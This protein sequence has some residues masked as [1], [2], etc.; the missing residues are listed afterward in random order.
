MISRKQKALFRKGLNII[1]PSTIL[2]NGKFLKT[3]LYDFRKNQK[4]FKL[5]INPV[6]K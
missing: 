3:C 6:K 4:T 2:Y 1:Y 5:G